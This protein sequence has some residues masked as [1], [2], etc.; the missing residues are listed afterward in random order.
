MRLLDTG[1][2]ARAPPRPRSGT[3]AGGVPGGAKAT[4]FA[5]TTHALFPSKVQS[6]V[7][8]RPSGYETGLQILNGLR[9]PLLLD[10]LDPQV[11]LDRPVAEEASAF[12]VDIRGIETHRLQGAHDTS[13]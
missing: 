1:V 13:V 8:G 2:P 6:I 5:A 10:R 12:C 11:D 9:E 3:R 4:P 7:N